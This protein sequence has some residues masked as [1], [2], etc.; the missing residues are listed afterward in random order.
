MIIK[1]EEL[2]DFPFSERIKLERAKA[3]NNP[4]FWINE[5]ISS[6]VPAADS[7]MSLV[8]YSKNVTNQLES[9]YE[10]ID[11]FLQKYGVGSMD[12]LHTYIKS[13]KDQVESMYSEKEEAISPFS[14][15]KDLAELKD[16][17]LGME[18]QLKSLY[19]ERESN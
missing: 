9:L 19:S 12:E 6:H 18:E 17:A 15:I 11:G 7:V 16:M 14:G 1:K 2:N 3:Q 8:D 5:Y 10:D 4:A 13:L